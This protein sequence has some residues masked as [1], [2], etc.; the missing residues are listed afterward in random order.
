VARADPLRPGL[1]AM[2][3]Q[4]LGG[5]S[6]RPPP[7]PFRIEIVER[8]SGRTVGAEPV[9][10]GEGEARARLELMRADRELDRRAFLPTWTRG[11]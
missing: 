9:D 11:R 1:A 6:R 2:A 10:G 4:L 7:A 5:L 3:S 8:T